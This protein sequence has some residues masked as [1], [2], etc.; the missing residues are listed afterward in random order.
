MYILFCDETNLQPA[1]KARFFAFG[2]L[3]V[4]LDK[5]PELHSRVEAIRRKYR[6]GPGDKFKFDTNA[7][8]KHLSPDEGASAKGELVEACRAAGCVFI[9]SVIHHDL[10]EG[11]TREQLV[12]FGANTVIGRFHQ[13]LLANNAHGIVI[14][15]RL[16]M[17]KDYQ[18]LTEKFSVGL[19]FPDGKSI[20]LPRICL[21]ASS[22]IG[23]SHGISAV[24]VVLGAFRY[25][26]NDPKSPELARELLVQVTRLLWHE[27]HGDVIQ[28]GGRGL[29][30]RPEL[31]SIKAPMYKAL[32][33]GLIDDLNGI[34]KDSDV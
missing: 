28:V 23:A 16:P 19:T 29:I 2:G 14:V 32:Y 9:V 7:R 30:M 10:A 1:A 27:R 21:V 22:C 12:G 11:S 34:I 26:I 31:H 4:H 13:Y 5:L 17:D 8:P 24:D 18:Y 6:Y 3:I 20:R 15:D 25:C 33:Q